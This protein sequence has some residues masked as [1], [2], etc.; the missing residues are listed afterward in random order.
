MQGGVAFADEDI[1]V[2]NDTI[3]T[4]S[5]YFDGSDLSLDTTEV[6]AFQLMPDGSILLSFST[7]GVLVTDA[8]EYSYY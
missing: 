5:V 2:Y 8:L 6:D 7:D 3:G 4:W 1:I